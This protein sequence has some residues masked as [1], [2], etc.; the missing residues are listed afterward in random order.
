MRILHVIGGVTPKAGGPS[1]S[2]PGLCKALAAQGVE[3]ALF[4]HTDVG[5]ESADLGGCKLICGRGIRILPWK[6][7]EDF[8]SAVLAFKPQIV[9]L[10]GVWCWYL[11][12]D[13]RICREL[14]IP[15]VIAP[16]GSL[17]AWS[18]KQKWLKKKLAL[19][20]YQG[21]DLC[22]AAAIH[23]TAEK[24]KSDVQKLIGC[25]V[26]MIMSANGINLPKSL[27]EWNQHSDGRRRMLFLSRMNEKKGVLNL[28]EAWNKVQ[29]SGWCC[30]L[31]YSVGNPNDEEY[32]R[33][34]KQRVQDLGLQDSFI[35]TGA[36]DNDAK[37]AAYR[38]ADAFV[39]PTH[40]ENFGI[41]IAE[42]LY[43][44]LP[45]LTTKMA[46]WQGLVEHNCGL[47]VD[48]DLLSITNGLEELTSSP[49]EK[50]REMGARGRK[51]VCMTYNW[52]EL[53]RELMK[54]YSSLL[55]HEE[56]YVVER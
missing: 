6:R 34:V 37:W 40:T 23:I 24:E 17:D 15:Y 48:D 26:P 18:V 7:A 29:P 44:G 53:S 51:Y 55:C 38:R 21:N 9:H 2:V 8:R 35:F 46:P 52:D 3:I 33:K 27:P 28:V 54:G 20:L 16:R 25:G 13:I 32:E 36:L 12:Q 4:V 39:L 47:W 10:H 19:W 14:Q 22:H 31:V 49:A 30:E 43:A 5:S 45:V 11:H 56:P 1:R 41:V 42:A 50:L